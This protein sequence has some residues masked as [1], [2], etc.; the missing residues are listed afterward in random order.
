MKNGDLTVEEIIEFL[1]TNNKEAIENSQKYIKEKAV[2]G[3][4]IMKLSYL[5]LSEMAADIALREMN[6][7]DKKI[8]CTRICD[9]LF[10]KYVQTIHMNILLHAAMWEANS[11]FFKLADKRE[12]E[13][14]L[15]IER[16]SVIK[17]QIRDFVNHEND[18]KTRAAEARH[19]E[20]R[21]KKEMVISEW[22]SYKEKQESLGKSASKNA[23]AQKAAEKYS[24][25]Y[26]TIRKNWLQGL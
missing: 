7:T 10:A 2:M 6:E 23:F 3:D 21:S 14:S 17:N 8:I 4:K 26:N 16:I 9:R 13:N 20:N 25:S 5:Q 22:N 1:R 24:V 11:S 19:R 15:F 18:I 12:Q